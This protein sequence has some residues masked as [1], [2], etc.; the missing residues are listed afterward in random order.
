MHVGVLACSWYVLM[1]CVVPQMKVH[2]VLTLRQQTW[3]T[4]MGTQIPSWRDGMPWNHWP[5][6]NPH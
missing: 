3:Y 2:V 4:C 5:A 1:S 6:L